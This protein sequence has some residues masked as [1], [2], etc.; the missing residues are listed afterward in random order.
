MSS[1]L[2]GFKRLLKG[3][4]YAGSA[5]IIAYPFLFTDTKFH[6]KETRFN[7]QVLDRCSTYLTNYRPLPLFDRGIRQIIYNYYFCEDRAIPIE[8]ERHTLTLK[9]GGTISLDWAKPEE[10]LDAT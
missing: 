1:Y 6:Y 7:K 8:Y 3:G 5:S 9:D 10:N 2:S 4:L